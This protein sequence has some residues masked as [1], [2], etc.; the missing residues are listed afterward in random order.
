MASMVVSGDTTTLKHGS[1]H[2]S[3]DRVP[4]NGTPI[5]P[6]P[7]MK[8]DKKEFNLHGSARSVS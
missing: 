2:I 5:Y 3:Y 1:R 7:A 8:T 4:P 6:V